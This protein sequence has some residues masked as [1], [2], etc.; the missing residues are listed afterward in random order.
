MKPSGIG[1]Q[2]VIEGI[3]MRNK[4]KY[5]IAV[6]KP[7]NEIEVTVRE[8]KVLTEKHK[9]MSY[10]V[11][12]GVVSFI[13]SLITGISTINYSASFYDDP[14]EQKKTKAD[15]I[16]KS[17]FKDKFES[18]LMALTV[19]VS[20]FLA[21]GLFMLLP[22]YVSRLVKGYVASKTLLNLIEGLVRVAIFI[23]YLVLISLMK[24]IKRTFMYHGAEHKC[25]N[26]IENGAR[27]TVENVMNSSRYHKRCGTSFLFIV[28]F[29]SVVFFIFIRVDNTALQIV[30]RLLLVPV[31][32]GVSYEFIRWAG[33]NDNGF[34]VAL[35]RP[36][37]WLQKLTTREPDEDMVEVA[38][39]A[40][41]EVFDWEAFL[42]E[43]YQT[44]LD[45]EA[46][47]KAAEAKLALT[48]ELIHKPKKTRK[49]DAREVAMAETLKSVESK[50]LAGSDK[51]KPADTNKTADKPDNKTGETDKHN[52]D[53][54][55]NNK[56]VNE[57]AESADKDSYNSDTDT[58]KTDTTDTGNVEAEPDTVNAVDDTD[59]GNS[60]EDN[61]KSD[62]EALQENAESDDKAQESTEAD[63]E[64]SQ[65]NA[66]DD[67]PEGFEIEDH[68]ETVEKIKTETGSKYAFTTEN[69][70]E[71]IDESEN[72]SVEEV[73]AAFEIEETEQEEENI[74]ADE[75]PLFKQR[76]RE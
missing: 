37:M 13:D 62:G 31:I 76:D 66:D 67:L 4:D 38:I 53:N 1:G 22:Y 49:I 46:D 70:Q 35:S 39:K 74:S 29:I 60:D 27:L 64:T 3:M 40:V 42:K 20:V 73:E 19:I 36:G 63:N 59:N 65:E 55:N 7:D 44:S 72:M 17:I 16:G 11:I 21:V 75:V 69:V 34:T 57:N 45:M 51:A 41:E 28:M 54:S 30:I 61:A 18:V 14:D 24:D 71:D 33:R 15:E 26:C 12:R 56:A 43:Y 8:S 10:P 32:A 58:V 6:R 9:W 50:S 52:W 47:I 23:L 68:Y 2:A 48:G 5:S 25:I